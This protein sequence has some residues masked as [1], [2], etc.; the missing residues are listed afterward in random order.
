[1]ICKN[2]GKENLEDAKFC[3]ACGSNLN[4]VLQ[5]CSSCGTK[6]SIDAKFCKK[7]GASL[8]TKKV[9]P[10]C[11]I[12][13]KKEA[14]YC[15]A[16]GTKFIGQRVKVQKEKCVGRLIFNIIS[17]R[18][19]TFIL[20]YCFIAAFNDFLK[21]KN[22]Q[23][24]L[25]GVLDNTDINLVSVIKNISTIKENSMVRNLG[26]YAKTAY[27]LP[28]IVALL[29]ILTAIVGCLTAIVLAIIHVVRKAMK[30][31]MPNLE[32]Y[33]IMSLGF[34]FAGFM[35]VSLSNF[36][37]N[38]EY[39]GEVYKIGFQ[40]G[41]VVVSALCI[42]INWILISHIAEI[43][44]RGIEGSSLLEIRDRIFKMAEGVLLIILLFNLVG[45]FAR[46]TFIE[47][48]GQLS[49]HFSSLVY[50]R[51]AYVSAGLYK[52]N[53][54]AFSAELVQSLVMSPILL[55]F[56]LAFISIGI[57]F[58]IRRF[59][60]KKSEAPKP[61]LCCGIVFMS[62]AALLLILTC[63]AAPMIF[64]DSNL[65][66]LLNLDSAAILDGMTSMVSANIIVFVIFSG[67]LLALEIVWWA[68]SS[69]ENKKESPIKE[70]I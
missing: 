55:V 5:I 34:F 53:R 8:S 70:E 22:I 7:C 26:A 51:Y 49:Y 40:Y 6:N 67:A 43:V 63:V 69:K 27:L 25:F 20:M 42:G 41:P 35:V 57:L 54:D 16:C 65:L 2:C 47:E 44:F 58:F 13:N 10:N 68:L 1:M 24:D 60:K 18:F 21:I 11:G 33:T 31:E 4:E 39:Y 46:I 52:Y 61:S 62:M 38:Y 50:F 48:E 45:N 3:S 66:E 56:M 14:N 30:K 15:K 36:K 29:G 32:R 37:M 17:L 64:R 12:E 9:C 28:N 59:S 23:G 19:C